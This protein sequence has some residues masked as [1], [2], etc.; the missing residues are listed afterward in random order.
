M[1]VDAHA[2]QILPILYALLKQAAFLSHGSHAN[3]AA[4]E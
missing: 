2:D 1:Y 4:A 3:T